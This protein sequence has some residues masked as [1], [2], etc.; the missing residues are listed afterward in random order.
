MPLGRICARKTSWKSLPSTLSINST[1]LPLV[2]CWN[3]PCAN[4]AIPGFAFASA[5][6]SSWCFDDQG[7]AHITLTAA[8]I[9]VNNASTMAA[10]TSTALLNPQA[11][12]TVI[13][14]SV[15]SLPSVISSPR[16][17]LKGRMSC[18]ISGTPSPRSESTRF[19]GISPSTAAPRIL[20]NF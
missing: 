11:C 10:F 7:P 5:S 1:E 20:T 17:R 8:R 9:P 19:A 2:A 18:A 13:S 6:T 14:L 15:Y 12:M 4:A 16:N 3:C